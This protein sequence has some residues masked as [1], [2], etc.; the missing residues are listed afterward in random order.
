MILVKAII[1]C[2]VPLCGKYTEC[3]LVIRRGCGFDGGMSIKDIRVKGEEWRSF[4]LTGDK[5]CCSDHSGKD[6]DD[7][8]RKEIE[9]IEARRAT[10]GERR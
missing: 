3:E 4:G 7:L 9:E 5:L 8:Y 2:D 1:T 10:R 6:L